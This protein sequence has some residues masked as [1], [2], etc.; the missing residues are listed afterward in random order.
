[1]SKDDT[2]KKDIHQKPTTQLLRLF[3]NRFIAGLFVVLP[4]YITYALLYWLYDL[5]Y[6]NA[7]EPIMYGLRRMWGLEEDSA[8]DPVWYLTLLLSA[9]ALLLSHHGDL[10]RWNV[11]SLAVASVRQLGAAKRSWSKNNLLRCQQS[12]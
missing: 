12:F 5:F 8:A 2:L 4:I 6:S 3:R 10:Y 7:L 1:M 11:F 9:V